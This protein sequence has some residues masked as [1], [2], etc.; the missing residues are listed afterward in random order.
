MKVLNLGIVGVAFAAATMVLGQ[1]NQEAA[2]LTREGIEIRTEAECIS[3]QRRGLEIAAGVSCVTALRIC[4]MRS[5]SV[6]PPL[7]L[8]E[9][10]RM[11]SA[12]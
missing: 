11:W 12:P 6:P 1:G 9:P 8:S 4:A 3:F 7:P 10:Q 5:S 2:N